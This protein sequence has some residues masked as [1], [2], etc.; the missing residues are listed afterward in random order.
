MKF[1]IIRAPILQII[2]DHFTRTPHNMSEIEDL[3]RELRTLPEIPQNIPEFVEPVSEPVAPVLPT[4]EPKLTP[5]QIKQ[6]IE[7]QMEK[8]LTHMDKKKAN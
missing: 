1:F 3:V 8:Q 4:P 5:E 7:K 2:V 6:Q